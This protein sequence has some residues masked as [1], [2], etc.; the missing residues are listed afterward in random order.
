MNTLD[1]FALLPLIILTTSIILVMLVIA[2]A[3]NLALTCL[4]CCIGLASTLLSIAWVG[5]SA[6]SGYVTP[7]ILVDAYATLFSGLIVAAGIFISLISYSYLKHRGENQDEFILL[8]MLSTLGAV[9]LAHSAHFVSFIL[10]LELV[11]VSLYAMISYPSKGLFGLEAALKYLI[12]SG[13]SSAFILFG[14]AMM[15]AVL[16][17]L[18]FSEM[19]SSAQAQSTIEH[20]FILI[21]TTMVLAGI[22]FKLSLV[23][24]HMWTPDVY[25]GAPAPAT[26][27]L[28]TISKGGIFAALLR[29]FLSF[30]GYQY[31]LITESLFWIA[32]LSIVIGNVLA[33]MQTKIKRVLAYSSIAHLGYLMVAFV[34]AS[35]LSGKQL[36]IEASIF[37]LFAYFIT[38]IG[39]FGVV[40]I[41]SC[42][43]QGSDK[44]EISHYQGL[45]WR[46]PLLAAF[47][48]AMLLS[49]AGIPLT[50]G[51]VGKF[52]IVAAGVE[53][54]LWALLVAV[55]IGSG[56]GLF[57]YLRIIFSMTTHT[58]S[59]E[60][61]A[62][63]AT[64]GWALGTLA[65]LL[66]Y[67]GVYPT[68]VVDWVSSVA[69]S[70]I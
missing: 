53:S 56:I 64:G 35:I 44:D 62:I 34:S 57:Y 21:G 32:I 7:L 1:L 27:L 15:F 45:F 65:F 51:F 42:E 2:F 12:L 43:S 6:D 33:L 37:F 16:G 36:A 41:M 48:S 20:W 25:E 47:F 9:T 10:G 66:V 23:P 67:L 4:L 26:A 11:G 31:N 70:M 54:E 22:G 38:T 68:L 28:A 46:R 50:L 58:G 49:L 69:K 18:S 39:A 55:V 8:L 30:D 13:V 60:P 14:A 29:F 19:A 63:P 52:Y 59:D 17:T 61:I 5:S 3:R 24:F 40:A